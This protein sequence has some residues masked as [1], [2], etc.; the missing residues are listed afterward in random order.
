MTTGWGGFRGAGPGVVVAVAA[1]LVLSLGLPW[2]SAFAAGAH[3][4][5][6]FVPGTCVPMADGTLD[7]LGM[8][9]VPGWTMGAQGYQVAGYGS[10]ARVGLVL[11]LIAIL[12]SQRRREPRF[13]LGVPAGVALAVLSVGV[14]GLGGQIV[15][16]AAVLLVAMHLRGLGLGAIGRGGR[17]GRGVISRGGPPPDNGPPAYR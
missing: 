6:S 7:C 15:A 1:L 4:P 16:L 8:M 13:L 5:G 3:L 11:A 2:S 12:V 14:T 10:T 9:W 17:G